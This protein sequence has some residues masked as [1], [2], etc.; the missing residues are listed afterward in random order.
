MC[1]NWVR[2][3]R[4]DTFPL[5]WFLNNNS[6]GFVPIHTPIPHMLQPESWQIYHSHLVLRIHSLLI[7]YRVRVITERQSEISNWIISSTLIDQYQSNL[8]LCQ[9]YF[10]MLSHVTEL[11]T[12]PLKKWEVFLIFHICYQWDRWIIFFSRTLLI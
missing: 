4:C 11:E 7:I 12:Y 9:L 5:A 1:Q 8:D 2:L 10:Y 3:C 6:A